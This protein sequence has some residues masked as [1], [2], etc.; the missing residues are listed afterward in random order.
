MLT[1]VVLQIRSQSVSF[2]SIAQRNKLPL[3]L[4]ILVLF[5]VTI[6]TQYLSFFFSLRYCTDTYNLQLTL[7]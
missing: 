7:L 2:P 1:F 3:Q 6:Y 5:S 4:W